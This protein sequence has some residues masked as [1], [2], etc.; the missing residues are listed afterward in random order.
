MNVSC[1]TV[2]I[3]NHNV[4]QHLLGELLFTLQGPGWMSNPLETFPERVWS[5]MLLLENAIMSII[6]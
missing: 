4:G 3:N 2:V 6:T 5:C 1:M